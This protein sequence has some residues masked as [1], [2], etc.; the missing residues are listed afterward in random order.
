MTTAR[1]TPFFYL[2]FYLLFAAVAIRGL[3]IYFSAGHPLRWLVAGLLVIFGLLLASEGWLTRRWQGYSS[4]YLTTQAGLGLGLSLL[5]PFL[6][7]FAILYIPLSTQAMFFFAPGLGFRWIGL[8]TLCMAGGLIYGY[9]WLEALPFILLYGSSYFFVGSYASV[10][11]QA[12]AARQESQTL[13]AELQTAHRQL[14]AYAAQAE[15]L[16]V[17]KERNYLARELHDSV[18]QTIFSI[19]LTAK[20]ARILLERNP[21]QAVTQLDH[22]Q[23]LAQSALAEM[24]TLIFQL[25]PASVEAGGL[26]AALRHHTAALK[27]RDGLTVALQVEGEQ[28]LSPDQEAQLFRIVQEALNNVVKHAHTDEVA[29]KLALSPDQ[30]SLLVEDHGLGFDITMLEPGRE[31]LGLASMRERAEMMGGSFAIESRPGEGV[32]IRV[33]VPLTA[34]RRSEG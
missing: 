21:A 13:L 22:L 11:V 1:K 31:T 7:F 8:F 33:E 10:T 4:F 6:D 23:E 3:T 24:R 27:S 5:P 20:S 14:Q 34:P 18:T 9:G 28:R 19:T 30:V 17:T 26:V 15:E 25:R 2:A 12:E 32:R 29:V 16:A